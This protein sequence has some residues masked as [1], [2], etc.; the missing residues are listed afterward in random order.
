MTTTAA[1]AT[2]GV[3]VVREVFDGGEG[4][5]DG[6]AFVRRPPPVVGEYDGGQVTVDI[7]GVGDGPVRRGD[8]ESVPKPAREGR[9]GRCGSTRGGLEEGYVWASRHQRRHWRSITSRTS[10]SRLAGGDVHDN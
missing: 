6:F 1:A 5:R 2:A 3:V 7:I 4:E 10:R 9:R 8:F